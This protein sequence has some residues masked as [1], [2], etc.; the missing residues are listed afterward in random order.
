MANKKILIVDDDE[1]ICELIGLYLKKEGYT[2][3]AAYDGEGAMAKFKTFNPDL[4]ILDVML[5]KMDGISFCR[6][7]RYK[8]NVPIIMLTAKGETFDK[9]LGLEMGADDY[10][11]KPF[12]PREFTLRLSAV[13]KRTYAS[14]MKNEMPVMTLPACVIDLGKAEVTKGEETFLLT[15]KEHAI[16]TAL[17]RNAN[18]VVTTDTL[19]QCA[20]GDD[21]YGYENTLM[22]HIRHIREKIEINPSDPAALIT[23]KGLGYK[24]VV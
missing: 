23:V 18:R 19:C 11:V 2:T 1:N 8:S 17:C 21:S 15:A 22:V 7:I 4:I 20:W 9:V 6:E 5:P 3:A 16:L 13:L 14:A 10:I 12:H 24:L